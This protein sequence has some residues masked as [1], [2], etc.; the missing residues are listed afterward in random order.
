MVSITQADFEGT[1]FCSLCCKHCMVSAGTKR[2][3][4]PLHEVADVFKVLHQNKIS[5][6]NLWGG[7]ILLRTDFYDMLDMARPLFNVSVQTNATTESDLHLD[8]YKDVGMHISLEGSPEDTDFIRGKGVF[9]RAFKN[10]YLHAQSNQ[11]R[12]KESKQSITIRTTIFHKNDV[13]AALKL[14]AGFGIK[15]YGVRFKPSGRGSVIN[16]YEPTQERMEYIYQLVSHYREQYGHQY[17]IDEPQ[18]YLLDNYYSNKYYSYFMKRGYVCPIGRRIMIDH[19]ADA[20]P[21]PFMIRKEFHLGNVL[22]NT[23]SDISKNYDDLIANRKATE[24]IPKCSICPWRDAC[25][26]G[27][28]YY[29]IT[30]D[31][32]RL[33]DPLCPIPDMLKKMKGEK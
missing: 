14:A 32:N 21:C 7:E 30:N 2:E 26:G 11:A 31:K 3:E 16:Q 5:K 28:T 4:L 12:G 9:K 1:T 29:T 17:M 15:W 25:G 23:W 10:L 6:L 27:C 18:Y 20:Y 19:K 22:S 8:K 33:G 13:E 24:Y